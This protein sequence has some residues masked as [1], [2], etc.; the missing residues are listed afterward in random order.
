MFR[1][2]LLV[3]PAMVGAMALSAGPAIAGEQDP[4]TSPAP[5]PNPARAQA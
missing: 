4:S 3:L 5:S 2:S 1:R